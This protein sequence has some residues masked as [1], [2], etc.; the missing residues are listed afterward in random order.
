MG[1]GFR[2]VK[3][4]AIVMGVLIVLGT[5]AL[6]VMVVKRGTSGGTVAAP[7]KP[8]SVVLDEP[9]GTAIAGIA[10]VRDGLAIQLRG[11]GPDRILIVDPG[12]GAITGRIAPFR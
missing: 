12:T 4:A 11:G 3:I 10:P 7:D 6:I 5:T 1:D 2:A 9:P 8:F